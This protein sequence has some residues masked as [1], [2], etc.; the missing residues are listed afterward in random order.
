M[1]KHPCAGQMFNRKWPTHGPRFYFP[2]KYRVAYAQ[3]LGSLRFTG[4]KLRKRHK[5]VLLFWVPFWS[6]ALGVS[7]LTGWVFGAFRF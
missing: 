7:V 5:I 1:V 3:T 4:M 2:K 6:L